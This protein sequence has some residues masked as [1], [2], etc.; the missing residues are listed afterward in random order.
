MK[1][2]HRSRR[3]KVL[4]GV[5]AGFAE[6]FS[7]DATL[8]RLL[9]ALVAVTVPSSVLAY[10]LAWIIIPEDPTVAAAPAPKETAQQGPVDAGMAEKAESLPPTAEDLLAGK[11]GP[12]P[13]PQPVPVQT[14]GAPHPVAPERSR[15]LFGYILVAIG[16]IVLAKRFV[17]AFVWGLPGRLIGQAWP[18]LIILVGAAIIF[19][20]IRGR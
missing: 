14:A 18:V 20:A 16:I 4:G 10:L 6:Y 17:P 11:A 1:R 5:A 9:F 7:I 13:A 15:Q 8:M 19:G 3:T 12:V 2:L